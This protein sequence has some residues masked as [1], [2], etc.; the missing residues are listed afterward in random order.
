M[1]RIAPNPEPFIDAA[2]ARCQFDNLERLTTQ[3]NDWTP[4]E[5]LEAFSD[6]A[7]DSN[8]LAQLNDRIGSSEPWYCMRPQNYLPVN[9]IPFIASDLA[10]VEGGGQKLI[11]LAFAAKNAAGTKTVFGTILDNQS[12]LP[13]AQVRFV[14]ELAAGAA[15]FDGAD[16]HDK[17]IA[18]ATQVADTERLLPEA[19]QAFA[20]EL[21]QHVD[22]VMERG[23]ATG[24]I[25][26]CA[27]GSSLVWAALDSQTPG[28]YAEGLQAF[29]NTA[30]PDGDVRR[31]RRVEVIEFV[32]K[33]LLPADA[34]SRTGL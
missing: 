6:P 9:P 21:A 34:R 22:H 26:R 12:L 32:S 20:V 3:V 14:R 19:K 8:V 11:D 24:K 15:A 5:T 31:Q 25:D 18:L 33:Q 1:G 10:K 23:V 29:K 27:W 7:V 28:A 30:A 17:V 16:R 2:T 13:E 4:E